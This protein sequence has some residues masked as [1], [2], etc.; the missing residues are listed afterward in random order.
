MISYR[1][2]TPADAEALSAMFADCFTTT[3]GALYAPHNLALFLSQQSPHAFAEQLAD[4]DYAFRLAE[5]HGGLVGFLK[6]GPPDLPGDTPPSPSNFANS[7]S[8][9]NGKAPGS[10]PRSPIG[11][12]PRP[13][14]APRR[15]SS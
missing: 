12:S 13:A 1:D 3:F 6:L 9:P 14:A 11:R 5:D 15:T 8:F 7:T 10:P 2:A 4:P